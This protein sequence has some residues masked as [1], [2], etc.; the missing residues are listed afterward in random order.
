MLAALWYFFFL[1]HFG[2]VVSDEKK[3][4]RA[5]LRALYSTVEVQH[6]HACS[7]GSAEH[8]TN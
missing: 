4:F 3:Q 1:K 6:L 2:M 7:H 5:V 8:A